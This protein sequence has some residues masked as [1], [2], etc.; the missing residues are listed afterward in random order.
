M[1][2]LK[3]TSNKLLDNG[4][5]D[6]HGIN[7]KKMGIINVDKNERC[8]TCNCNVDECPGHFGYISLVEP[9]FHV[10][11]I[12]ECVKVLKHICKNCSKLLNLKLKEKE[13]SNCKQKYFN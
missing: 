11:H 3:I 4:Q 6:E 5:P 8:I 10:H 2:V 12:K 1:A 13:C 9:V 7:S